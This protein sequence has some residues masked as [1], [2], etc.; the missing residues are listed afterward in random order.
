MLQ[1]VVVSQ[2]IPSIVLYTKAEVKIPDLERSV[3]ENLH[4][5]SS[6]TNL[7]SQINHNLCR[8]LLFNFVSDF[9]YC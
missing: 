6:E 7:I 1:S 9:S 2:N 4:V 5:K 3:H 8:L